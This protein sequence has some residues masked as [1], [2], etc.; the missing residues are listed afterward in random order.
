LKTVLQHVNHDKSTFEFASQHRTRRR[1]PIIPA[2]LAPAAKRGLQ[3]LLRC[4]D[5]V[6]RSLDPQIDILR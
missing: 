2:H 6:L 4:A 1:Q 3:N 5:Q